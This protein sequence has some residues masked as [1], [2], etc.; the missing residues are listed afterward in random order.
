MCQAS[1]RLRFATERLLDWGQGDSTVPQS[2]P[3]ASQWRLNAVMR[4]RREVPLL[5]V[6]GDLDLARALEDCSP[7]V[8]QI[9]KAL[10]L[11]NPPSVCHGMKCRLSKTHGLLGPRDA[12][13]LHVKRVS[14]WLF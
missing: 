12:I 4:C 2:P 14:G 7:A 1:W 13:C 10:E 5:S 3:T 9:L 8:R 11:T 6:Q